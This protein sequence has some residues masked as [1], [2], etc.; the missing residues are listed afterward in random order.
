MASPSSRSGIWAGVT[1]T[2]A[3]TR[4]CSFGTRKIEPAQYGS[5]PRTDA[6]EYRAGRMRPVIP[7]RGPARAWPSL[8][9]RLA[10]HPSTVVATTPTE[11]RGCPDRVPGS[12]PR[13]APVR[14]NTAPLP[15]SYSKNLRLQPVSAVGPGTLARL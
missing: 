2:A 14:G 15:P 11:V 9:V 1:V 12:L 10:G 13:P 5:I 8:P 4:R 6:A 7:G 3:C